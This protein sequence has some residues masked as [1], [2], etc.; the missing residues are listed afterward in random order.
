MF[1]ASVASGAGVAPGVDA[2]SAVE[3]VDLDARVVGQRRQ[4]GHPGV[5]ARLE[6]GVRLERR[7]VLDRLGVGWH[8][9]VV[10]VDELD[11]RRPEELAQLAQLV[12]RAGRDDD[13]RPR[14][15]R[16]HRPRRDRVS[17]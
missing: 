11:P 2:G 14:R 15:R 12:G 16:A 5:V 6:P 7:A 8:A 17:A 13:P 3:R 10:E 1:C 9:R 4:P